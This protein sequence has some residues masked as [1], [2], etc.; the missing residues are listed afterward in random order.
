MRT[1]LVNICELQKKD[2]CGH[3]VP[4]VALHTYW[5]HFEIVD[6]DKEDI[7]ILYTIYWEPTFININEK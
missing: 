5:K 4:A 3:N 1:K 6:I 2:N 7:D